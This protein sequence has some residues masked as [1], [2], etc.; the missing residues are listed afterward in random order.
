ML[1][2]QEVLIYEEM[3]GVCCANKGFTTV[4]TEVFAQRAQS[5]CFEN[6]LLRVLLLRDLP[7]EG[8][9]GSPLGS[10]RQ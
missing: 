6:L 10:G 3:N 2:K 5:V 9:R 1:R 4:D 8:H 7:F